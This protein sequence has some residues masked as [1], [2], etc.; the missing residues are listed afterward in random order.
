L[1]KTNDTMQQMP[2]KKVFEKPMVRG[3]GESAKE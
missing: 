3:G 1:F 2:V